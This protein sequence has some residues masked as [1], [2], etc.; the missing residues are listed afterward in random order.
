MINSIIQF[1]QAIL[2]SAINLIT[3]LLA[4]VTDNLEEVINSLI[5]LLQSLL[6]SITAFLSLAGACGQTSILSLRRC[7]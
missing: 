4:T 7:G 6:Q 2:E 5:Q 1:L 3:S